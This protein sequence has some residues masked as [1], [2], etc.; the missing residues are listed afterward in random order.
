MEKV[1]IRSE[2]KDEFKWDLSSIYKDINLWNKDY[3]TA[4]K[5]IDLIKKYKAN[6]LNSKENLLEYLNFSEK[7]ERLILK[8]YYY[9][10]LNYD[11]NTLDNKYEKLYEKAKNL[12]NKYALESSFFTPMVIKFDSNKLN[13]YLNESKELS[14]YKR[15]FD[16]IIRYKNHTL[17]EDKEEFI[18]KFSKVLDNPQTTYKSLIYS[19]IKFD[20]VLDKDNNSLELNDNNYSVY[21]MSSDRILR[22]NAFLNLFN[23]YSNYKNIIT[24]LFTGNMESNVVISRLKNYKNALNA[25]QFSENISEGVY[26]NLIKVVNDNLNVMHKFYKMKKDILKLDDMHIYDT[27]VPLLNDYDKDFSFKE[28]KELAIKSLSILG[29]DYVKTLEKAFDEKWIDVYYNKGKYTGAY[30]SGFYDINPFVLLN[31]KNK[32]DDVSTLVHELGH[33]MHTYYSCKNNMYVYSNYDI[34]VAEVASTVNELLLANYMLLNSNKKEEKLSILNHII[35]MFKATLY[36][37]TMF[38]EFEYEIYKKYENDEN[39]TNE[40]ISEFYLSLV[41]KY[42]GNNVVIDEEIKYEW[43]RIPHFYYNFYVYK[44]ATGI[45]AACYI[46]NSIINGKKDAVK[47]Y[48]EFLKTGGS[49][50][51][52][53]ELKIAGVDLTD[54]KTIKSAIDMFDS[55]IDEFIKIYNS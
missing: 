30:S 54:E 16:E 11:S 37:Q 27:Y 7:L 44:Y 4:I 36:R 20:N 39:L 28:A 19:D 55:Y 17:S 12:Y 6:F 10:H 2:I 29:D 53:D 47:N 41:K 5:E 3:E 22:K 33:S 43:M 40:E 15:M 14:K 51:P 24:K 34:F 26:T 8:I 21:L 18:H 45:S 13:L 48:I 31:Y 42:H 49:M 38:A 25:S 52:L 23:G 35:D 1:K 32:I 46:V 50:Y 9:A